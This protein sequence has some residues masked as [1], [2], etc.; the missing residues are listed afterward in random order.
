MAALAKSNFGGGGDLV[1]KLQEEMHQAQANKQSVRCIKQ[2]TN[3]H[4]TNILKS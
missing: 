3:K 4:Q 1:S 2:I